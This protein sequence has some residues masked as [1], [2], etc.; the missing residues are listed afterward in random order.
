MDPTIAYCYISNNLHQQVL[1]I[2]WYQEVFQAYPSSS[3][4]LSVMYLEDPCASYEAV[5]ASVVVG[6]SVTSPE[7]HHYEGL[8]PEQLSLLRNVSTAVPD[9]DR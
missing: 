7:I 5:M 1:S 6:A 9:T 2:S 4:E 3:N 8:Q